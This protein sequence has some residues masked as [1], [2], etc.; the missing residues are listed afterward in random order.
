MA[1]ADSVSTDHADR[2]TASMRARNTPTRNRRAGSTLKHSLGLIEAI[3]A[4]R[5]R[6]MKVE[7]ILNCALVAMDCEEEANGPYYPDI[8]QLAQE[9]V[10]QSIDQLD[11]LKLRPMI[12]ALERGQSTHS[13]EQTPELAPRG[14]NALRDSASVVYLYLPNSEAPS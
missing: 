4:E 3:E 7:S 12:E 1:K 11:S 8:L 6:L 13:K 14:E 2:D 5:S 9:L 10:N